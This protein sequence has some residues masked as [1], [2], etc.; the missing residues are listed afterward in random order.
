MHDIVYDFVQSLIKN[1]CAIIDVE[2]VGNE[3]EV[4]GEKVRHL[5][6]LMAMHNCRLSPSNAYYNDEIAK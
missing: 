2:D 4:L 6:V 1:E 3:I 5:T